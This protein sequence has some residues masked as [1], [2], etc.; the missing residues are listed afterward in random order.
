MEETKE[1]D[2]RT[3]LF[4]RRDDQNEQQDTAPHYLIVPR[5]TAAVPW[6]RVAILFIASSFSLPTFMTGTDIYNNNNQGYGAF[7]TSFMILA[8]GNAILA[9]IG[10]LCGTV[11]ARTRMHSYDL[12]NL[13]FGRKGAG[14]FNFSFA[15][16]LFGW[17]V[18]N[19]NILVDSLQALW[20]SE[21]EGIPAVVCISCGCLFTLT[22]MFGFKTMDQLSMLLAPILAIVVALLVVKAFTHEQPQHTSLDDS[23][24]Q[25]ENEDDDNTTSPT[26]RA[27]SSVAGLSIMGAIITSDYTRFVDRWRGAI[28][29]ALLTAFISCLVEAS[30][31]WS[32]QVFRTKNL[33]ELMEQAGLPREALIV[34]IVGGCWVLNAM[35]LF[36][37][38]LSLDA[39]C[40]RPPSSDFYSAQ[41]NYHRRHLIIGIAGVFGSILATTC[42]IL[43]EFLT[44]LFYLSIMFAPV[45]GVFV[46]DY[47]F[48][49]RDIY[50]STGAREPI[51]HCR[52]AALLSWA[53]GL[54][55]ALLFGLTGISALDAFIAS[56]ASYL[57]IATI[58]PSDSSS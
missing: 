3:N 30:V 55:F 1:P 39:T 22:A 46:V 10:A 20:S 2:E 58:I 45:S 19:L 7:S 25:D 9:A 8:A 50:D 6:F 27:I 21:R 32:S 31:G 18:V 41:P 42:N 57:C 44:F 29:S 51:R 54:G 11:G 28:W 49:R 38:S 5:S 15:I 24:R 17:F 53:V 56:A 40:F 16:S 34:L 35:N 13:A 33:L 26:G 4:A 37:L 23:T 47:I 36:S 48:L 12:A 14:I 52:P 43:D